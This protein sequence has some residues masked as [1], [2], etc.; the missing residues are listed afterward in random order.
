MSTLDTN[1]LRAALCGE[2]TDAVEMYPANDGVRVLLPVTD[3]YGDSLSLVVESDSEGFVLTDHGATFRMIT[4]LTGVRSPDAAVWRRVDEI[5]L[6][7]GVDFENG[8]FILDAADTLLLARGILR[9]AAAMVEAMYVGRAAS[10][11]AAPRKATGR[12][13][14]P[15]P[16]GRARHRY[17]GRKG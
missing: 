5:A 1:G 7:H 11:P 3:V 17:R 13:N 2:L 15:H 16:Q 6:R 14:R 9:L 4:D 10:P 8:E 12:A